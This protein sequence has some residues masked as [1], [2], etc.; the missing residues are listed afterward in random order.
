MKD[1]SSLP[2]AKAGGFHTNSNRDASPPRSFNPRDSF[3]ITGRTQQ[4]LVYAAYTPTASPC[5]TGFSPLN[6]VI[7]NVRPW[8]NVGGIPV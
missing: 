3:G 2:P 5:V 8:H 1:A 6:D 7:V 4:W